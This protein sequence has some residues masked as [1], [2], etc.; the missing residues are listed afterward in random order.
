MNYYKIRSWIIGKAKSIF[1][2]YNFS[3]FMRR[4]RQKFEKLFYCKKYTVDDIIGALK[5]AG[6]KQG[7]PII[8]HSAMG[9][10]Y[11]FE[12]TAEELIRKL[13]DFVGPEG[14]VCMPAYPKDKF[15]NSQIFDIRMSTSAAGYLSEIFRQKEGV[16]RSMNQLHSVCAFGKDADYIT[17]DHHLSDISFDQYSPFSRIAELGGYSVSLGMPKWYIGTGEHICEAKL[18]GRLK[19]FTEKFKHVKVYTYKNIDGEI[20]KHSMHAE[21]DY[22]FVRRHSTRLIDKYF[23]KS[24]YGRVKLSNIWVTVF[25][26]DYL[27]NRLGELA[28]QGKTIYK[29]PN[30][31]LRDEK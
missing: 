9:N 5:A 16:Y 29:Y 21:S 28:L 7:K 10:F 23:D 14:T 17:R 25:D 13:L 8:V 30:N 3:V 1:R 12:G 22:Q 4:R 26:M 27:S 24:K 20:I 31:I 15:D 2:I 19:I 18:F 6:L 11:N